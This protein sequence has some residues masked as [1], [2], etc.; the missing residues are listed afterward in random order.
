[1]GRNPTDPI[2]NELMYRTIDFPKPRCLVLVGHCQKNERKVASGN[3]RC[4]L[5]VIGRL[6]P[7][8][9]TIQTPR[10]ILI[11]TLTLHGWRRCHQQQWLDAI[12]YQP[13]ASDDGKELQ[14]RCAERVLTQNT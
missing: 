3:E 6:L 5:T 2:F 1:M 13:F 9:S 10:N 14:L 11:S 7:Q 12:Y 4:E 8:L